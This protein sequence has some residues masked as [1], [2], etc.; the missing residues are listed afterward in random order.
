MI[1]ALESL[2]YEGMRE[3]KRYCP[4]VSHNCMRRLLLSMLTVF[5]TKSTPTVG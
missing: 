1:A 4:A 5:D 2:M 3:W